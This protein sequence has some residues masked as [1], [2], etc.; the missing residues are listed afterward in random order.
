M[1]NS[2]NIIIY[3]P[4]IENGG[5]EKNLFNLFNFLAKKKYCNIILFYSFINSKIKKKI[6]KKIRLV[7]YKSKNKFFLKRYLVSI[8][9]FI[10]F[11]K[12][13]KENFLSENTI[14]FSAQNSVISII[15][16]K[17]LNLRIIVR[18]GNHPWSALKFSENLLLNTIS[19]ILKILTYNFANK[20]V[21]NSKKT[22]EFFQ[23][24][25]LNKN[26]LSSIENSVNLKT[27]PKSSRENNLI[28]S[29]GRLTK[30]KDFV[31]LLKGFQIFLINNKDYKLCILGEGKEKQKLVNLTITL[32][33]KK[34]V[35]FKNYVNDP[36]PI[37]SN[38]KIYVC[39]SLYE[40]L[41]SSLI[42]ALSVGTPIISTDCSS[43]PNEILENGK[44]GYLFKIK[45]H[46]RLA[47]LMN[48]VVKNYPEA[49]KKIIKGRKT[50]YKY[51]VKNVASKYLNEIENLF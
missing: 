33:I 51:N 6:S 37:F 20:I 5:M 24:F 40:G 45:D 4:S 38:S 44:F 28:V 31:T 35:I 23:Y 17:M 14:I 46:Q 8:F 34:K 26:K 12:K 22:K 29:A 41:P 32:G 11:Y 21:C 1:K 47:F 48:Y 30:Q 15:L 3:F 9:S 39:T 7:Q 49:K 18:N 13:I 19:F 43:G 2:K 50:L 10:F 25:I 16:S 27:P 42:E 36:L